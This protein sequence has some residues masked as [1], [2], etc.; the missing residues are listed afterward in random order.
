VTT[1]RKLVRPACGF[2]VEQDPLVP[3]KAGTQSDILGPEYLTLDSRLRGNER[4]VLFD[5]HVFVRFS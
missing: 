1:F 2:F 4:S 3:A 5:A